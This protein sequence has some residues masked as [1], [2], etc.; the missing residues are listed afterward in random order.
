MGSFLWEG[1]LQKIEGAAEWWA[2]LSLMQ[3]TTT[4]VKMILLLLSP[5]GQRDKLPAGAGA[6]RWLYCKHQRPGCKEPPPLFLLLRAYCLFRY[7]YILCLLHSWCR[8]R[9]NPS[10]INQKHKLLFGVCLHLNL[11]NLPEL[12]AI[13][14]LWG[15]PVCVKPPV[16]HHHSVL[17]RRSLV[18]GQTRH[19]PPPTVWMLLHLA[20]G[21]LL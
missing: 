6:A 20:H 1:L 21:L 10:D 12:S 8:V 11:L 13:F 14:W 19:K 17:E 3:E 15:V 2:A 4:A 9:Y 18:G 16:L 5:T 7:W